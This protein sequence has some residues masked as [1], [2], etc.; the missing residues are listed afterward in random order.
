MGTVV[1]CM[2]TI[3]RCMGT[4]VWCM[5]TV[6]RCMGTIV[7]AEF[8]IVYIYDIGYYMY[9]YTLVYNYKY[10]VSGYVHKW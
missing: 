3:V 1:R 9:M 2:G 6:V 10:I 4:I 7:P 5:G 8:C